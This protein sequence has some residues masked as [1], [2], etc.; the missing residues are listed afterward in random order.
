MKSNCIIL[1][2]KISGSVILPASKSISNRALIIKALSER[3]DVRNLS[4]CDDTDAVVGALSSS[5]NDVNVG[6]AGTAMR[7]LTAYLSLK[8][9]E[10]QITGSERMLHRPIKILVDA[11]RN[12]GADIEYLN[13]EGFPPLKIKG[14]GLSG[15]NIE[16]DGSV[17]SQF[18]SALLMIAPYTQNGINMY[19]SG[20]ISSKPYIKMTLSMMESFGVST[21]WNDNVIRISPQRYSNTS[22]VV[23]NDWSAASYWYEI[24]SLTENAELELIGLQK[25]SLQGDSVVANIF[26]SLGVHTE[27]GNGNIR[28]KK[29]ST[30]VE[31]LFYDFNS[32]PDLAQTIVLTCCLLGVP[33]KFC[34]LQSLKIKE[35]D[36]IV[37]LQQECA[38][39]GFNLEET[40]IGE[41]SWNGLK[42]EISGEFSI[43]TYDDHR[44]AMAFAPAAMCF[45][46]IIINNPNVV[47]KSYPLFWEDLKGHGFLVLSR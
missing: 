30:P 7:F 3:S 37:A 45:Q 19:L 31:K 24:V 28:I 10:W 2:K 14:R 22:Y 25:N 27:Y 39:M 11:L 9:G 16:I 38:K 32:C 4:D 17:S 8:A 36:R 42:I 46:N 1:S 23:E 33:F 29:I 13:E 18:L 35:T 5:K 40:G 41:L 26:E 6:A 47:S 21:I 20:N 15:G 12:I 43:D 44:M 34:G